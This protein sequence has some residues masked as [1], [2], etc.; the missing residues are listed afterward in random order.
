[1]DTET[2]ALKLNHDIIFGDQW[3]PHFRTCGIKSKGG[4]LKTRVTMRQLIMNEFLQRVLYKTK[5][6]DSNIPGKDSIFRFDIYRQLKNILLILME[7]I[8]FMGQFK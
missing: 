1:M 6:H 2:A 8:T 3:D 5:L 7:D 4:V